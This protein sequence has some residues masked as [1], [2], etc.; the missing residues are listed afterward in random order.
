M[1]GGT[2]R[3][4][5]V[6]SPGILRLKD[7]MNCFPFEDPVVVLRVSGHAI[8]KA[9]ENSVALVPALEGRYCQVA[10]IRFA[11]DVSLPSGARVKWVEI[12]GRPL[13]AEELYTVATRGY[14]GRGKDGFTPLLVRS[15]GGEA[16]EVVSEENGIL[17]SMMLRQYFMSLKVMRRWKG[18]GPS[19]GRHW[20]GVQEKLRADGGGGPVEDVG[21]EPKQQTHKH[22]RSGNLKTHH[23][24]GGYDVDTHDHNDNDNEDDEDDGEGLSASETAVAEGEQEGRRMTLAR[25]AVRHWMRVAG[26]KAEQVGTVDEEQEQDITTTT[27]TTAPPPPDW[28]RGIAPRLE[29][30]IVIIDGRSAAAK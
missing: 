24:S 14:M 7:I 9:L 19:M 28:T 16:E 22:T 12:A 4:D 23:H 20:G 8:R 13:D 6:Y 11:Y 10:G 21:V 5:Q 25:S 30:R 26:I 3:G 17:I 27:T 29:G 2:I 15:E 1:A 18:W